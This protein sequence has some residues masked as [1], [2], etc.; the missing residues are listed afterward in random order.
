MFWASYY[1][2]GD[3]VSDSEL[4]LELILVLD[5]GSGFALSL[6]LPKTNLS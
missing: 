1:G 2:V 5:S 3:L 6:G 4:V